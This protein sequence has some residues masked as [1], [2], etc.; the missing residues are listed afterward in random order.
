VRFPGGA[1]VNDLQGSPVARERIERLFHFVRELHERRNPTPR[2]IDEHPWKLRYSDLPEHEA[3]A[4]AVRPPGEASDSSEEPEA[5]P[6][7]AVLLEVYRPNSQEAPIRPVVLE[8]WLGKDWKDPR[9]NPRPHEF[10]FQDTAGAGNRTE[11]AFDADPNRVT[12]LQEYRKVWHSWAEHGRR[13]IAAARI[14]EH[15]YELHGSLQKDGERFELVLA[16]GLLKWQRPEGG[17]HYPLLTKT[18]HLQFDPEAPVFRIVETDDAGEFNTSLFRGMQDI[19]GPSLGRLRAEADTLG[20]HPLGEADVNGFL[21]SVVGTISPHGKFVGNEA[22]GAECNEPVVGRGPIFLLRK[23]VAG[24]ARAVDAII[25]DIRANGSISGALHHIVGNH[26]VA[27]NGKASAADA[28]RVLSAADMDEEILFTKPANHEQIAIAQ[29]LEH[30]DSVLV[31]GPPGTGKTHTIGNLLGH[32]LSQGRSVLVVSHT[33]KALKVLR[34]K[35]VRPLQPLCVSVLDS[36]ED[37]KALEASVNGI[38][39]RIEDGYGGVLEHDITRLESERAGILVDIRQVQQELIDARMDEQRPVLIGGEATELLAAA[40]FV[41]KGRGGEE[42]HDWIPAGVMLGEPAPLIATELIELYRT[43][44]T[45]SSDDETLLVS[46]LPD[47]TGMPSPDRFAALVAERYALSE[48]DRT[49][50]S[51][52]WK[53]R[54]EANKSDDGLD[55]FYEEARAALE[56]LDRLPPW[57]LALVPI[58]LDEAEKQPWLNLLTEIET[59]RALV[60]E[61]AELLHRCDPRPNNAFPPDRASEIYDEI[62]AEVRKTGKASGFVT[63]TLRSTWKTALSDAKVGSGVPPRLPEHFDA[64][65]ASARI[66]ERRDALRR[67]WTNQVSPLGAL[68]GD[69]L[70]EEVEVKAQEFGIQMRAALH[71][72]VRQ[73]KPMNQRAEEHGLRWDC[74]VAEIDVRLA[75]TQFSERVRHMVTDVLPSVLAAE[76]ARRAWSRLEREII[77]FKETACCWAVAAPAEALRTAFERFDVDGYRKAYV[78]IVRLREVADQMRVR[79]AHL[80]KLERV[81]PAWAEAIRMRRAPHHGDAPLGDLARAW[82]WRQFEDELHHRASTSLDELGRRL[83]VRKATLREVTACLVDRKAWQQQMLRTS[84]EQRGALVGFSQA[85]KKIGRGFGKRAPALLRQARENMA[86]ARGAVPVW[87]MPLTR[88]AEVFD[89]RTQ[90]FDVVIMDEASQSDITGLIALYLGKQAIV[91]GDDEQVSPM[92]VGERSDDAQQLIDMYLEGIPNKDLFDGRY[93]LYDLAKAWFGGAICLREHF[94]CVPDI[95]RF[96]NTLSYDG[97]IHA[98]REGKESDPKPAVVAHRVASNGRD[99]KINETEARVVTSLIAAAFEQPEYDGKT[100]GVISLVGDEQAYRIE[101]LLRRLLVPSEL[102]HRRLLSGNAAQFQGDERN[103]MFLSVVDVPEGRPLRMSQER[104]AQQRF[105]VAASRAQDQMWVVYSL[106]P[107]IDLQPRDLRRRLIEHALNPKAIED[108]DEAL[109]DRAESE[110]EIDVIRCLRAAGYRLR[111]QHRVGSYRIDIVVDHGEGKRIA[112]ECDGDRWH[113]IEDLQRDIARQEV[114]E[115]VGWRFIRI[116]GSAFYRNPDTA[117]A[118]VFEKLRQA[119]IVPLSVDASLV[120][121]NESELI[122]RVRRRSAEILVDVEEIATE[123]FTKRRSSAASARKRSTSIA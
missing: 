102:E 115:R 35:V 80:K 37:D 60:L 109:L 72:S 54:D 49:Y 94:R 65:A 108:D 74:L 56:S 81:A 101:Q 3:V 50:R 23:R 75:N 46:A 34:E 87:I 123:E 64:L 28:S 113:R 98:L 31:Q 36:V 47:V 103:V 82:R 119:G 90:R 40:K 121:Q 76:E 93:S 106:D 59:T 63:L 14:F 15:L 25:E 19:D 55:A 17:I 44:V 10:L 69:Q 117:M 96:S 32:L 112:V 33:T 61:H 51:D 73:W 99:G 7:Q 100:F 107:S 118:P 97:R 85:K 83:E 95:I 67:R 48:K 58:G 39:E 5:T 8:N 20:L 68:L 57:T 120:P 86:K 21:R 105:N 27:E 111:T 38:L 30:N 1:N 71:W 66:R 78:E 53:Q 89:P 77:R 4:F 110:F 79:S 29:A 41:A 11:V 18:V 122:E 70:G 26:D 2:N 13:T 114:L 43:N 52:V 16:D 22:L 84:P 62:A 9:S 6:S 45:V 104:V 42:R 91:V 88:A 24:I 12:A 116:R 92:A